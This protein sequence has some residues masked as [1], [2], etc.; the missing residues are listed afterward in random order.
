MESIARDARADIEIARAKPY[1]KKA[2]AQAR[3]DCEFRGPPT[4]RLGRLLKMVRDLDDE[5]C[6]MLE[7]D[8]GMLTAIADA[9]LTGMD[10]PDAEFQ[11][12]PPAPDEDGE[13][14]GVDGSKDLSA[15]L[16]Y[17]WDG[18][19]MAKAGF[20][21]ITPIPLYRR[22][23][24]AS[25]YERDGWAKVGARDLCRFLDIVLKAADDAY[26]QQASN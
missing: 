25:R 1:V 4:D 16:G 3:A 19:E 15:V 9:K 23:I 2:L 26:E 12:W 18:G 24:A 17:L 20:E 10:D 6:R 5:F 8:E 7:V 14:T 21:G 13:A 11:L 22:L